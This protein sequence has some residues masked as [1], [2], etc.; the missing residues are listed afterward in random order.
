VGLGRFVL[1]LLVVMGCLHVMMGRHLMVS[2][3]LKVLLD[4]FGL[5]LGSHLSA[6]LKISLTVWQRC[7]MAVNSTE[8]ISTGGL[9]P[10]Q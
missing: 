9:N 10:V 8:G 2:G 7:D 3:R 1:A 5:R 4:C 6:S